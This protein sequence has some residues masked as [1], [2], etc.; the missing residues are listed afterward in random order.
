MHAQ[1]AA[2]LDT[3]KPVSRFSLDPV[4]SE[5]EPDED[6]RTLLIG[7]EGFL[8]ELYVTR[9]VEK[10]L[11]RRIMSRSAELICFVGPRG[12]GKTSVATS[13]CHQLQC[14]PQRKVFISYLDVRADSV[15]KE[16][17]TA[18][19]RGSDAFLRES[20]ID[21][22]LLRLF[23]YTAEEPKP[24]L[25]LWEFL[26]TP[27][28]EQ[29]KPEALFHVF[30]SVSEKAQKAYA[31]FKD[32]EANRSITF[33]EWLRNNYLRD[34]KVS[35]IT[36]VLDQ[37]VDIGHLVYAARFLHGYTL[38]VIWVDNIDA[39]P[40]TLQPLAVHHLRRFHLQVSTYASTIVAV[41]EENVFRSEDI[42]EE[43]PPPY[44]SRVLL[45]IPRDA[46]DHA[47]YPSIDFPAAKTATVKDIIM[48]RMNYARN[49]QRQEADS[50]PEAQERVISDERYGYLCELT[51]K[52]L[53][54]FEQEQAVF[55]AN[56][57]VR[58][59]MFIHRD[60]LAYLLRSP[61]EN[62][63]PPEALSYEPWYLATLFHAWVRATKRRYQ[64]GAYDVIELARDWHLEKKKPFGC[65][66]PYLI[67]TCIWNFCI[68]NRREISGNSGTPSIA[69]V[70]KRLRTLGYSEEEI[71]RNIHELYL[72]VDKRG[73]IVGIRSKALIGDWMKLK[74]RKNQ[75]LRIYVTYR[76]KCL[77]LR[78]GMS[79]GFIAECVRRAESRAVHEDLR[80]PCRKDTDEVAKRMLPYLCDIAD[81]H[82]Q[83]LIRLRA[84]W[85]SEDVNW[86]DKYL[87]WFGLPQVKPYRRK[88]DIGEFSHGTRRALYFQTLITSLE[89]YVR[90]TS[91]YK[92]FTSLGRLYNQSVERLR[93]TDGTSIEEGNFRDRMGLPPRKEPKQ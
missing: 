41:R 89:G 51:R 74:K 62:I 52:M 71:L 32:L 36:D 15:L 35:A 88:E 75:R 57:C 83:A 54:V 66:L 12:C 50:G 60:C 87:I 68:E 27:R 58:D 24:R 92:Q 72:F 17:S 76:G 45:E 8:E 7:P 21:H 13:V 82:Y 91:M 81:M 49:L 67:T 90:Y 70:V 77:A 28:P 47:Y 86:F 55:L 44:E 19:S 18:T 43:D 46:A 39:L 6:Q 37:T 93:T 48:R 34:A 42:S 4:L 5:S 1:Y 63:E 2:F 26:L 40:E 79:F 23:P 33:T 14:D 61:K 80:H 73:H 38:Q 59:L 10:E 20:I 53:D 64:I 84:R 11:L 25:E 16:T 3:Y 85:A 56:N 69:E 30:R 29:Q 22:Y 31:T 78:A 9:S 65:F